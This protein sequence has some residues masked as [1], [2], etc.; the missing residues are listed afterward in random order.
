MT[1]SP[2]PPE[3][4]AAWLQR[5]DQ[6]AASELYRQMLPCVRQAVAGFPQLRGEADDMVQQIMISTFQAI[7]RWDGRRPLQPW[8]RTLAKRLCLTRLRAADFR[9]GLATC[10]ESA[11]SRSV[12]ASERQSGGGSE[13]RS[14]AA[15]DRC[16]M[17][18][19]DDQAFG[20]AFARLRANDQRLLELTCLEGRSLASASG[21]LGC[22]A[23]TLKVRACRARRRLACLLGRSVGA[24]ERRNVC[25]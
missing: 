17:H 11:R 13:P 8:L 2:N 7:S 22:R 18:A 4:I 9:R 5:Q 15:P 25:E 6:S 23:K 3:L 20:R 21:L 12:G 19:E 14:V 10:S 16:L 24:E 1:S